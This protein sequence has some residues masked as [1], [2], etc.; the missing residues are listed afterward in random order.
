MHAKSKSRI[1]VIDDEPDMVDYLTSLL[2]DEGYECQGANSGTAGNLMVEEFRPDLICLDIDMP[3]KTGVKMYRELGKDPQKNKIPVIII[4]G[5]TK[6]FENFFQYMSKHRENPP[7]IG[8]V[9]KPVDVRTLMAKV[10]ES[11]S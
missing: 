8:F 1:L 4:S 9:A 6:D 11:L 3:E 7:F 10:H 5:L 2:E